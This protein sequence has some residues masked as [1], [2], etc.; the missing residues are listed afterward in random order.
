M[1]RRWAVVGAAIVVVAVLGV[2]GCRWFSSESDADIARSCLQL[3]SGG[4]R[5]LA[6]TQTERFRGKVA[7]ETARC[8][9]GEASVAAQRTPWVDWSSYFAAGDA[10]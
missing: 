7:P 1:W 3:A 9:G 6:S 8:R 4:V 2:G 5:P 10:K